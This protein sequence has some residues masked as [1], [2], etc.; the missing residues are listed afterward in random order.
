MTTRSTLVV[1][2]ALSVATSTLAAEPNER[3]TSRPASAQALPPPVA[4]TAE[5]RWP[6]ASEMVDRL[7]RDAERFANQGA[8][9]LARLYRVWNF[10][11]LLE[12]TDRVAQTL[13]RL[14][15]ARDPLLRDHA[16]YLQAE[17]LRQEGRL[18]EAQAQ[19]SSLGLVTDGW[20][21]GPFDN[22]AG[23]GHGTSYPPEGTIELAEPVDS[24]GRPLKWQRL[25]GLAP[26]GAIEL[27]SLLPASQE[28]TAYVAV[29]AEAERRT[30]A[31]LRAGSA[32]ALKVWV[33]GHL[34]HDRNARRFAYLDQDAVGVVLDRGRNLLLFKTSW[35]SAEQGRLFA[36][37]T[38]RDGRP[39]TRVRLVADPAQF[40]ALPR[41]P[42]RR[43]PDVPPI[44]AGLDR[45]PRGMRTVEALALEADLTAVM[46]LYDSRRLPT[47]AEEGLR[48]AVRAAPGDPHLRFF[49]AHRVKGRDPKLAR[50]QFLAAVAADPGH[51]PAWLALGEMAREGQRPLEA[52][53]YLDKAVS[54]DSAFLPATSARA[55]LGFE[56]FAEHILAV[57]R[58]V[59]ARGALRSAS[60][61]VELGRL[62]RALGDAQ[63]ARQDL[64]A[65]L[66]IDFTSETARQMLIDI[67]LD[68]G[69]GDQAAALAA[70][71]V[72]LQPWALGPRLRNIKL[73][74]ATD[75]ER[76]HE[77]LAATETAFPAHPAVPALR[78]DLALR[79]KET[80]RA[81]A[82]LE[83]SLS[84]DPYQPGLRRHRRRLV[85]GGRDIGSI[86]GL[87]AIAAAKAPVTDLERQYGAI[88]LTDRT[89]VELSASGRSTKYRQQVIRIADARVTDALRAHRV[90]YSPSREA[91]EILAAEQIRTNGQVLKPT[92]IRDDGP[93]GK[94]SG[95]YIDQ[96]YK[97]IVFGDL[98]PG[99][100][101]H[102]AYRIDTRGENIFGGF[103]GDVLA[104]QGPLPKR[105]IRYTVT[106]PSSRPLYH[107]TIRLPEPERATTD[108]EHRLSWRL[109]AIDPLDF[110]P[111]A[112]PYPRIGQMLSISTYD[113]W[114]ELGRWYA[115]LYGDQLELDESARRAG[116]AAVKGITDPAEKV[117]RLYAYVV[118]NTGYVGIELGIHGWKPFK[119]SE[120]HRRRYG[121]CK[122]K[123]TLLSAL[124]RDN[125]VAATITLVRTAD[126]GRL[127]GDHATM[128]AFNHAITYVPELDWYLDPT[129]EF[130]GSRE[131]PYQDQGAMALVV[132]PDGR[133]KLTTLPL[134]S[135]AI[136]LTRLGT[137]P[138]S[139]ATDA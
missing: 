71:Q 110:E 135:P 121:D 78:A 56:K 130:N 62:R 65:A 42:R 38:R 63:R 115:R 92:A 86:Y 22:S 89:G 67:A 44:Q 98:A 83:R 25:G 79:A 4:A 131:L 13:D 73:T 136:T 138:A 90:F 24:R 129:A 47:P 34:V 105:D 74:W 101:L 106:A 128:W 9:S 114:D 1:V 125:G 69:D 55:V 27:A 104:V 77:L 26:E 21:I 17:L 61:R 23:R 40:E 5:Q 39:L 119:A 103:F 111:L 64:Q 94:V 19:I 81:V 15:T 123:S 8:W 54:A 122:D 32:D 137:R 126:R 97:V 139:V 66:K 35:G 87:D 28:A 51:A 93:K 95:M 52:R 85:G 43:G 6:G 113:A 108:T 7:A 33:N 91:V 45:R 70:E 10:N 127:P 12:Q 88:F 116:R 31:I 30:P 58:L 49:L 84:L 20:L 100:T 76:A 117:R 37:L 59:Q 60:A 18:E 102:I 41:R 53:T 80:D 36:R 99:D 133:T 120:V 132:H 72:R 29:I 134:S 14:S 2:L 112:P 16:R 46:G 50:E 107:A 68:A 3:A 82:A 48:A 96:R 118:K 57:E 75:P 109:A 124:L 11:R